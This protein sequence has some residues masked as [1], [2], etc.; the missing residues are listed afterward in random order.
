MVLSETLRMHPP[1]PLLV[2]RESKEHCVIH[3]YDIP[4]KSKVMVNAWAIG[5]D[6]KSWTDPD[7]FY[8]ERFINNSV[9]FKGAN[10][11]FIPFGSGRRICPGTLFGI[12]VVELHIAQL[13]YHFD[14][15]IPGGVKPEDLDMTE[16]FGATVR[17]KSHL[18]LIPTA[19]VNSPSNAQP[20]QLARHVD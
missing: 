17:R 20:T 19:Y 8:P 10:Y 13:L 9:D 18:I 12:A 14:W 6:P 3:G 16:D 1:S 2:P 15:Q 11:E 4:A 5:R 7:R